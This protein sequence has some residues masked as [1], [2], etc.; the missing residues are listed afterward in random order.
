[1]NKPSRSLGIPSLISFGL[2][3]PQLLRIGVPNTPETDYKGHQT[4]SERHPIGSSIT[5]K[6]FETC[7]VPIM[8]I[9]VVVIDPT[10]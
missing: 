2:F 4:P 1:M 5:F 10:V 9:R 3:R 6:S 8:N 7:P